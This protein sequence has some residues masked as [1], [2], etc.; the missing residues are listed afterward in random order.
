MRCTNIADKQ[1][2]LI[3]DELG[4]LDAE[5]DAMRP[6]AARAKMLREQV[7]GWC[8]DLP[9]E[10][11]SLFEG[12]THV[13]LVSAKENRRAIVSMSAVYKALGL[14]KFLA[15]CSFT[16]DALEKSLGPQSSDFVQTERT[17]PRKLDIMARPDRVLAKAKA[18]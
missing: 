3:V 6:K 1:R 9:A 15:A 4:T 12:A 11:G 10:E 2:A 14:K 17:G 5:L 8:K 7:Q 16:L 18:A 13:V